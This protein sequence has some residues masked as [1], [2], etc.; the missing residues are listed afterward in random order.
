MSGWGLKVALH[1]QGEVIR[2]RKCSGTELAA[3]RAL[4][5][6]LPV[7]TGQLV[8]ARKPPAAAV[9]G[10]GVWLLSWGRR[11]REHHCSVPTS[12]PLHLVHPFAMLKLEPG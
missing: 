1:V 6:V 7:V 4:S 2:A 5:R 8:G 9:P 3:E 12:P 11:S 10:A